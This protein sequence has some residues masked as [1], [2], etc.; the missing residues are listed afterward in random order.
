MLKLGSIAAMLFA[1]GAYRPRAARA[2]VA[3]GG[4]GGTLGALGTH[5]SVLTVA[6]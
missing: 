6:R 2:A 4:A 5:R 1:V 3:T